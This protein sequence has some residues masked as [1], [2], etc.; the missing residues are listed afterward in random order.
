MPKDRPKWKYKAN[1]EERRR[2][3][4][5]SMEKKPET[6]KDRK[7]R[8]AKNKEN[9]LGRFSNKTVKKKVGGYVVDEELKAK[10][11]KIGRVKRVDW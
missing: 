7:Q 8:L 4:E 11:A 3:Q 1:S 10:K 5:K 2:L 9:V 6:S